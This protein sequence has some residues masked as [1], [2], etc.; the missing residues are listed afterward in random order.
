MTSSILATAMP[1]PTTRWGALTCLFQQVNGPA[2]N[3]FFAEFDKGL[4]DFFQVHQFRLATIKRQ[5]IDTKRSL[6]R[7][8]AEQ[9]VQNDIGKPHHV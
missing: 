9:L 8:K 4:N 1:R 5:H 3:D 2:R 6:K 7:G